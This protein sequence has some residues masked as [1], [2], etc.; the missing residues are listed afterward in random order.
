MATENR[1]E[2]GGT[3]AL[4]LHD[5]VVCLFDVLGY[6]S[7]AEN[8]EI[9]YAVHVVLDLLTKMPD[10]VAAETVRL[11][12]DEGVRKALSGFFD[13]VLRFV[14]SDT[15]VL[16]LSPPLGKQSALWFLFLHMCA[17]FQA[18]MFENGLPVRGAI[19]VG[20]QYVSD[21]CFVGKAIVDAYNLA[22]RTDW[23]GCVLHPSAVALLEQLREPPV[24]DPQ[25]Y[26]N[27]VFGT[28]VQK[29]LVPM[30]AGDSERLYCVNWPRT[31]KGLSAVNV[32]Q[33][34]IESFQKHSKDLTPREHTKLTNTELFMSLCMA[35]TPKSDA[36]RQA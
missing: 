28:V 34:V 4:Q 18:R 16:S 35:Q 7:L 26:A 25:G 32:R 11:A 20:P 8:A 12:T 31:V 21:K 10:E 2:P 5:G 3:P 22:R 29:Y 17:L 9:D 19:A 27:I 1:D 13:M 6:T 14:Y 24:D 36:S 23:S 15:V 33:L 30:K